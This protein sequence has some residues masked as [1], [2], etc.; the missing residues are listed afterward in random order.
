LQV[1]N[2]AEA[3]VFQLENVVGM[4]EGLAHAYSDEGDQDSELIVISVPGLM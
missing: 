4:V 2:G 1:D 3:V